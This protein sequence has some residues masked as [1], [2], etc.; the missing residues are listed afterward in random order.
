MVE[1][2]IARLSGLIERHSPRRVVVVVPDATSARWLTSVLVE[3][4]GCLVGARIVDLEGL[5][6]SAAT[7]LRGEALGP[8]E[9]LELVREALLGD[10]EGRFGARSA[11]AIAEQPSYQ[12]EVLRRFVELE[13]ALEGDARSLAQLLGELEASSR[14]HAM[15]AAFA[16]FRAAIPEGRWWTG[17]SLGL[18]LAKP[19]RVSFLR[20][21]AA[22]VALG[23]GASSLPR[24][25]R[26]LFERLEIEVW[27]VASEPV[28]RRG[29][30]LQLSCAGPEAEIAGVARML[31]AEPGVSS[32]ILAPE[33]A[34]ARWAERLGHRDVPVRAWVRQRARDTGTARVVR[35]LLG[36]LAAP[37]AV[38]R[39]ELEGV[40]FGT[41]LRVWKPESDLLGLDYP[42]APSPAQLRDVWDQQRASA[43]ALTTLG[44][45]IR[46]AQTQALAALEQRALRFAWPTPLLADRRVRVEQAHAL[47]AAALDRLAGLADAWDPAELHSLLDDWDLLARAAVHGAESPSMSAGRVILDVVARSGPDSSHAQL[48]TRLDHA[49]ERARVGRWVETRAI[50]GGPPVWLLPY[51]SAAVLERLPTRVILTGLDRHPIA[52]VHHGLVSESLRVRLGLIADAE[53]F[54]AQLRDLDRLVARADPSRPVIAS[55]R[56]RDGTG[57][58]RPPGP[59]IAGRQD[60]G[61]VQRVGVDVLA[62]PEPESDGDGHERGVRATAPIERDLLDWAGD[63]R[64]R[65]RVEAIRSHDAAELGPHTG[66]LGVAVAPER[67][68]SASAL[69][70]YA[71]LPFRYFVERVL[72]VRARERPAESASAL[73][74]TEQGQVVHAALESTLAARLAAQGGPVEL[75]GV[76]EPVLAELLAELG[77]GYRAQAEHGQAEPIWASERDRWTV[78]VRA[79]WQRWQERVQDGWNPGPGGASSSGVRRRP[80]PDVLVPSPFLLAVEWSPSAEGEAFELDLGARTIPFVA[81]VDRIEIDPVRQRLNVCDYKTGRPSWPGAITRDLR[82]GVHL[83]LP[84]YALAV[85][86]ALCVA[87]GRLG[88]PV[89]IPIGALRLEYLQRPR[90]HSPGRPVTPQARGFAPDSPLGVDET[91]QVWTILHAAAGFTLAFV[92]A[93]EA[94][95]FPVVARTGPRWRGGDRVHELARVVPSAEQRDSG[96][97]PALRPLPDP[98]REREVVQ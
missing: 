2:S 21:R 30:D 83:Q 32:A 63:P 15:L 45:R 6:G 22:A 14:D 72:G 37:H 76:G 78:E 67:P 60:E 10:P 86:Q 29:I 58:P 90:P 57:S 34:I 80:E 59:W 39:S 19:Q 11:E 70:S 42:R 48:A 69:Q 1:D 52:P 74:A 40:L 20:R 55:W 93:I 18:V 36:M 84:L 24:W 82:A 71:A 7:E 23:F 50:G 51:A 92:A 89:A 5:L 8:M 77:R 54:T 73:L 9:T 62:V 4:R 27:P 91:G 56:H 43:F 95:R 75:S 49:L 46:G 3:G 38:R 64:L 47:L 94:G 25:V 44:E 79:W 35:S 16:R 87:P 68:Y 53:R 33:A 66:E 98:Q 28:T 26:A 81:A 97:P 12:R 17:Q 65:R 31:R 96:L 41:A 88:L 61:R 85:Y 13:R